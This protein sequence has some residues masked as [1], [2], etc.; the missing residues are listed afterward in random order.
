MA[1]KASIEFNYRKVMNQ[2]EQIDGI[3]NQ[4]D[5]LSRDRFDSIIQ[6]VSANW[7]GDSA[8]LYV[9][10]GESL[11]GN[12][13]GTVSELRNIA[14]DIRLIARRLYIAEM[15]ALAAAQTREY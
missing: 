1:T 7:K 11:Q 12:M 13:N 2:A 14:S 3:A 8:S 10:K 5:H 6:G 4:L 9:S 15:A